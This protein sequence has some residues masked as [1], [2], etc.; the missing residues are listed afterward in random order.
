MS[1]RV[2]PAVNFNLNGLISQEANLLQCSLCATQPT[3]EL[4][5]FFLHTVFCITRANT[6]KHTHTH[7]QLSKPSLSDSR[8]GWKHPS[9]TVS[10]SNSLSLSRSFSSPM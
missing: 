8:T 4:P 10:L 5:V 3:E 9:L 6:H 7:T 1:L 2:S